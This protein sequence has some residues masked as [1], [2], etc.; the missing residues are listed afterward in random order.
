MQTITVYAGSSGFA[1][2]THNKAARDLGHLCGEKGITLCYGG[3]NAGLMYLV[4]EA[5]RRNKG[6]VIGVIPGKL[7]D[8]ERVHRELNELI[9]VDTLWERKREMYYR[10]DAIFALPGGFG[11]YDEVA[12]ILYWGV[13]GFHKKPMVMINIDGYWDD[14]LDFFNNKVTQGVGELGKASDFLVAATS[15][16]DAIA[17][18]EAWVAPDYAGTRDD[19]EEQLPHYED[20]FS[21]ELLSSI[22]IYDATAQGAYQI[23][24]ALALRQLGKHSLPIGILNVNGAFDPLLKWIDDASAARYITAKCTDLFAVSHDAHV[25]SGKLDILS[26]DQINLHDDKWGAKPEF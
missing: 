19:R 10:A 12:E 16:E 1:P 22:I 21:D 6:N 7:R 9:T 13:M 8:S 15:A 3:M 4:A 14:F 17:K 2:E 24:T 18:A 11:T 5:C 23:G 20:A 26:K 25:L